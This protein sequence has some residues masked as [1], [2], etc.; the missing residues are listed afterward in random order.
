MYA[1]TQVEW[2]KKDIVKSMSHKELYK[3]IDQLKN[4]AKSL[5]QESIDADPDAITQ[6][7]V[8]THECFNCGSNIFTIQ[9]T[10][11]D[12]EI[13]LMWPEGTCVMCGSVVTTPAPW[14]HPYWDAE[15][16]EIVRPLPPIGE[17][18]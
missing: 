15:L 2:N 3:F 5:S 18:E 8:P 16:K 11:D 10:F 13:G 1:L 4:T 14:D 12:Y 17:E 7:G 9:V 6:L